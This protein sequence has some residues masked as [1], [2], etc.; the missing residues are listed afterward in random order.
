PGRRS[1]QTG[2]ASTATPITGTATHSQGFLCTP[3]RRSLAQ[4]TMSAAL[5]ARYMMTR[6]RIPYVDRNPDAVPGL[7]NAVEI[8]P[9]AMLGATKAIAARAG[10]WNLG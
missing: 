8:T 2:M 7:V 3:R 1:P 9:M 5:A 10:V 6:P 4:S